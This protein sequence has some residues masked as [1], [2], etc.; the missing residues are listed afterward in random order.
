MVGPP[1]TRLPSI[2]LLVSV[3]WYRATSESG[4]KEGLQITSDGL[5]RLKMRIV[6]KN[7]TREGRLYP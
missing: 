1:V 2:T 7:P 6:R 4:E 5:K 3:G